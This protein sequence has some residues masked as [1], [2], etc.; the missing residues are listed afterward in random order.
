M[1]IKFNDTHTKIPIAELIKVK[2]APVAL[3]FVGNNYIKYILFAINPQNQNIF[4]IIKII[5]LVKFEKNAIINVKK[6]HIVDIIID[7]VIKY[8]RP[9]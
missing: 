8:L 6:N 9:K 7:K 3:Y 1:L 2:A 4:H 5:F